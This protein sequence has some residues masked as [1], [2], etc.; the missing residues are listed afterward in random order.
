MP[1]VLIRSREG[2]TM[3]R[4]RHIILSRR[5][6]RWNQGRPMQIRPHENAVVMARQ[7]NQSE[8][9]PN[10]LLLLS[11]PDNCMVKARTDAYL[12][13]GMVELPDDPFLDI[14]SSGGCGKGGRFATSKKRVIF[15]D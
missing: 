4:F 6:M 14:D 1:L 9:N 7:Q 5:E 11:G 2:K 13:P 12:T 10:V 3:H 8:K 15:F